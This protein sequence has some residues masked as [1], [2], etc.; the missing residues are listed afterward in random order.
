MTLQI[1]AA[2]I[3]RHNTKPVRWRF[4]YHGKRCRPAAP[5]RRDEQIK[6]ADEEHFSSKRASLLRTLEA[7]GVAQNAESWPSG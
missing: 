3:A 7:G 2:S 6:A 1:K 5:G 4:V